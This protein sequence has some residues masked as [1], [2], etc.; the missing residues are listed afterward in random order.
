MSPWSWYIPAWRRDLAR[1]GQE[2]SNE[3]RIWFLPGLDK[4]MHWRNTTGES[5]FREMALPSE[6]FN[7]ITI[8][9]VSPDGWFCPASPLMPDSWGHRL[10]EDLAKQWLNAQPRFVPVPPAATAELPEFIHQDGEPSVV[11]V[12]RLLSLEPGPDFPMSS[13][14]PETRAVRVTWPPPGSGLPALSVSPEAESIEKLRRPDYSGGLPTELVREGGLTVGTKWPPPFDTMFPL[15]GNFDLLYHQAQ[16]K[17]FLRLK[18]NGSVA[19]AEKTAEKH[20]AGLTSSASSNLYMA[21]FLPHMVGPEDR[22]VSA[23]GLLKDEWGIT[24]P[25]EQELTTLEELEHHPRLREVM[26]APIEVT[27]VFGWEGLFWLS[28]HSEL[29][30]RGGLRFCKRESCGTVIGGRA[31]KEYCSREENPACYRARAAARQKQHSA[32]KKLETQNNAYP[33]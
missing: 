16:M 4:T 31:N 25:E 26:L 28:L 27:R 10:P 9:H 29:P 32:K 30:V 12:E 3:G 6:T 1:A 20:L 18:E 23:F 24:N 5:P 13:Y 11:Y 8:I 14:D 15:W 2:W 21:W 17:E 22:R 7:R 33:K 19:Q